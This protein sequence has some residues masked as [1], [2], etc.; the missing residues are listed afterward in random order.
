MSSISLVEACRTGSAKLFIVGAAG[1]THVGGS[2]LRG[3]NELGIHAEL[4]DTAPAFSGPRLL[5]TLLWRMFD[6]RPIRLGSFSS[7]VQQLVQSDAQKCI[8][9]STGQ[10]PI[11]AA[12]IRSLKMAGVT[13][14]NFSTDDPWNSVHKSRRHLESLREYDVVFSPRTANLV[15]FQRLGVRHF[16]YVPFAYDPSLFSAV[17]TV[18]AP[19]SDVLFV[20]GADDDRRQFFDILIASGI[21]PALVGGY[22]DRYAKTKRFSLGQKTPEKLA[23]LT[24]A[25]KVNLCLVRRANRDGHVMRSF[26]IPSIG[27]FMMAEDTPDHR[28]M[29]GEDR[30]RVLYFNDGKQAVEGIEWAIAN[31]HQ[32]Q[33]MAKLLHTHIVDGQNTYADRLRYMLNFL[34]RFVP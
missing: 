15:D 2:L 27:G 32:R 22:W 9:I 16:V 24:M 21:A 30:E 19:Q 17:G 3:A 14:A 26:E 25:A 10:A 1:G 13:T 4:I 31:P 23:A 34:E 18:N 5:R 33:L 7:L 11:S 29:F 12:A 28:R 6:R 8:L 20:G